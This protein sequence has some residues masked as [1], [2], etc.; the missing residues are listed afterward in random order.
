V[1][2]VK[3]KAGLNKS[4]LEQGWSVF[5]SMLEYKQHWRGGEVLYVPPHHTSQIFPSCSHVDKDNR[6]TQAHFN[7]V[8]CGEV[9][10]VGSVKQEFKA[11]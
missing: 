5:A 9:A 10:L 7:C 6:K 11:A 2:N 8:A 4:I 1:R 3:A